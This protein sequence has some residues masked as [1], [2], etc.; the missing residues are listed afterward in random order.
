MP[1]ERRAWALCLVALTVAVPTAYPIAAAVADLRPSDTSS[2]STP[3]P[4]PP[5]SLDV[6]KGLGAWV[7]MYDAPPWRDPRSAVRK[8]S[9][10]GVKTLYLETANY[11]KPETGAIYR[12]AAVAS[13]L[14]AADEFGIAVVAWYVPGFKNLRRDIRR[15][16]AAIEF[17][18][19]GGLT[20]DSFAMDIEATVV[21]DIETRNRRARRLSR[22]VRE[23]VGD[24]YFLGAIVPEAGALYWPNFPYRG[25]ANIYDVFLPMAYFSYRTSGAGGVYSFVTNNITAVRSETGNEDVPV[26]LIGGIAED[27]TPREVGAMVEAVRDQNAFG[28]SLYDLPTT[29]RRQWEK[30]SRVP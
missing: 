21:R 5:R 6:Y 17:R 9:E 23:L 27:S 10:K 22:Q 24:D 3:L 19:E 2:I 26:H 11:H 25:L 18:T 28:A 29:T 7:D 16:R 13:F 20:F 4:E 15:S 14:E 8:M 1:R 12:P 30:L